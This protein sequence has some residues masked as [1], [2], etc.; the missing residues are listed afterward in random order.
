MK[1]TAPS[2]DDKSA[3]ERDNNRK[4]SCCVKWRKGVRRKLRTNARKLRTDARQLQADSQD[5]LEGA[6]EDALEDALEEIKAELP[7]REMRDQEWYITQ[8]ILKAGQKLMKSGQMLLEAG[9]MLQNAERML[10]NAERLTTCPSCQKEKLPDL[11]PSA[12]APRQPRVRLL[13]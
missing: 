8:K 9:Q 5:E 7:P 2:S 13:S 3:G 12:P 10:Q 11:R 1:P 6:L 4:R